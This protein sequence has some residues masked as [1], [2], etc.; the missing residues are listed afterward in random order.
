M[1]TH[2][3]S[4][5][6]SI[7]PTVVFECRLTVFGFISILLVLTGCKESSSPTLTTPSPGGELILY[8]WVDYIPQSV[9]DTFMAEYG[10][11]VIYITYDSMEEAERTIL[12]GGLEF[13]VAV[14]EH[15]IVLNLASQDTLAEI[16]YRNVPNFVNISPNFRDLAFDPGN[17][18]M[19]PY[20]WGTT[21]LIVRSDL[22]DPL[23]RYW[24]DL[25]DLRFS[26]RIAVRLQST[27]L[28]GIALKS[29]GYSP[30]SE[31]PAQLEV[32]LDRL[33]ELKPRATFVE[34]ES[35]LAVAGLVKGDEWILVGWSGDALLADDQNPAIDYI[36]PEDGTLLWGDGFVISA[37]SRHKYAAELFINFILRPEI[38]AQIVQEYYYS[39]ANG[40]AL[41]LIDPTI[42]ENSILFPSSEAIQKGEWYLSLTPEVKKLYEDIWT[43]F[44]DA[45]Q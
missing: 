21:G 42:R 36:L 11:K 7:I 45:N 10:V 14:V 17:R 28:I 39:T 23:P 6:L 26:G 8:N 4:C 9:L 3:R 31:D 15:D 19:V 1:R 5:V 24:A 12:D 20:N 29:A 32:A 41:D 13:D 37:R 34:V 16:D 43:R 30:N 40:A 33:L 44:I 18:H 27:E 22:V 25:W 2:H 38:G 35:E